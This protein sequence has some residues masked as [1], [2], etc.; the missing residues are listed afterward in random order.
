MQCFIIMRN[1]DSCVDHKSANMMLLLLLLMMMMMMMQ[2]PVVADFAADHICSVD[3]G[4]PSSSREVPW[5]Q[6]C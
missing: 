6:A 2:G 4:S 1:M 5:R 3:S